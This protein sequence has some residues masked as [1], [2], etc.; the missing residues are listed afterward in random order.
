MLLWQY[1]VDTGIPVSL[2]G[3]CS[4]IAFSE[5]W[6]WEKSRGSKCVRLAVLSFIVLF[7]FLLYTKFY[8]CPG[9]WIYGYLIVSE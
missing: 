2:Q 7:C 6:S 8:V 5:Q 9:K 1:M 3:R 4:R